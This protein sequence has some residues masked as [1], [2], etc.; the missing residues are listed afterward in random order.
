[1]THRYKT[2]GICSVF[3]DVEMDGNLVKDIEFHG[4]CDGNLQGIS[5]LAAGH[6][7]EELKEKLEGI[8]C[9]HKK[10]SC[11]DQLIK[12]IEFAMTTP[13]NM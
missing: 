6:T 9:G 11:P 13:P 12:A 2:N 10:T 8:H 5:H 1:M 4:G 3:I 7:Y